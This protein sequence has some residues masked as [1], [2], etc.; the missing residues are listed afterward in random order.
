MS[1][2]Y[3]CGGIVHELF[4][5]NTIADAIKILEDN[6]IKV[7]KD[8]ESEKYLL[9]Y[10]MISCSNSNPYGQKCR[11][12]I[13]DHLGRTI[14]RK[15]DRF[16]NYGE[17][18]EITGKVDFSRSRYF[19]KEDGS[20]IALWFDHDL[21]KWRISTK[22]TID[23]RGPVKTTGGP[24][25][26]MFDTLVLETL[27]CTEF[28]FNQRME[29]L[30][31]SL[32]FDI[33]SYSLVFELCTKQNKVI[34]DYPEDKMILLDVFLNHY[35]EYRLKDDHLT[36]LYGYISKLF[37]NVEL[38]KEI[39]GIKTKEEALE[40]CKTLGNLNEGLV[41]YDPV[42]KIRLKMKSPRYVWV[43]NIKGE[44]EAP[45]LSKLAQIPY[46]GEIE[47]FS[48]YFPEWAES[49]RYIKEVV[50]FRFQALESVYRGMGISSEDTT[51]E[52]MAQFARDL[53]E[54]VPNAFYQKLFFTAKRQNK[55]LATVF[56]EADVKFYVGFF[57]EA[58][59][60]AQASIPK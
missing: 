24:P 35:D 32:P 43:A 60:E 16:F 44:E 25:Y 59:K 20:L 47:E 5:N 51:R 14:A 57:E 50:D 26:K 4:Q 45:S 27:G 21:S 55:T 1:Y 31:N 13:V 17:M 2:A 12:V 28:E 49:L 22:G 15:Y 37:K 7:K 33:R 30:R 56:K 36:Q 46:T 23:G 48:A 41:I 58:H 8:T 34:T 39:H 18:I 40:Y 42:S 52:A 10:S 38:I 19:P 54:Q 29:V 3:E 9:I 53:K 6:G 11:G